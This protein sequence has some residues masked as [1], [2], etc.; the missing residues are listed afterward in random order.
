MRLLIIFVVYFCAIDAKLGIPFKEGHDSKFTFSVEQ[1]DETTLL[2]CTGELYIRKLSNAILFQ[3]H[4][5]ETHKRV[6]VRN[7]FIQDAV[8]VPI[9]MKFGLNNKLFH[10]KDYEDWEWVDPRIVT[11]IIKYTDIPEN[12]RYTEESWEVSDID[13][14][15]IS[16]VTD[17]DDHLQLKL[18]YKL[19]ECIDP[20]E[21]EI[22]KEHYRIIKMDVD[23]KSDYIT[24]ID[25]HYQKR[26][27]DFD[28]QNNVFMSFVEFVKI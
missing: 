5:F 24:K 19:Q 15:P 18:Y 16:N 27:E 2:D 4:N 20:V 9:M 7:K 12:G 1:F 10:P 22:V 23:K 28:Q 21:D 3:F 25:Y 6:N 13:C 11:K 8:S 14:P 17:H 26:T